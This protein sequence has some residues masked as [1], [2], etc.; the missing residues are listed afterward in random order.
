MHLLYTST[1]MQRAFIR[2]LRKNAGY[3]L[4]IL[5]LVV[6]SFGTQSLF[7]AQPEIVHSHDIELFVL[8]MVI[9]IG[10]FINRIAPQ[11]KIPSFV[12]ALFAGMA[13]EPVLS[14]YLHD[15]S[16]LKV[17]MEIF[18]AFIL[19]AGGL[20]I[21]FKNFQKWFFPIASLAFMGVFLSALLFA[22]M[23]YAIASMLGIESEYLLYTVVILGAILSS[24]DP[25]AIIPTLATMKFRKPF[26]KEVAISESALTDITG[27]ILTRFLLLAIIV[28]PKSQEPSIWGSFMPLL[29]KSSYEALALQVVSGV[30]IGYL[31]FAI[32]RRFY[33]PQKGGQAASTDD[34]ALMFAVPLFT[35]TLGNILGGAGFLASFAAGL[36]ADLGGS[37]KKAHFFYE[38]FLGDLV[39]PFIFIVLGALVP[40]QVL[41]LYAPLGL[42]SAVVFILVIRPFVVFVSLAPWAIEGK[43]TI[44]DLL[45]LSFIRE[46]GIIAAV[47]LIVAKTHDSLMPD[48]LV[49]VGMWIILM[50]LI[51]EPPLTPLVARGLNLTTDKR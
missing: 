30:L 36:F 11:T 19:F 16:G 27:S 43:F 31:G 45:F 46:T 3:L 37:L 8:G 50:T 4:L 38:T 20:E 48:F 14:N 39:K 6:I 1:V 5:F 9:F 12:W 47:L 44:R 41:L 29:Q 7:A 32:V 34:P 49:S 10:F 33:A 35:F 23:C 28:A 42:L 21:P 26:L 40:I 24:T 25:T 51:I 15:S 17:V 22:L 2:F 13:L 18:A